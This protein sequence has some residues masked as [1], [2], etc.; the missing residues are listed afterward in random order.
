MKKIWLDH[1]EISRVDRQFITG[2]TN[3]ASTDSPHDDE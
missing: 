3:K 2:T 1:I